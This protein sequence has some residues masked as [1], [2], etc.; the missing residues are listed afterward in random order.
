MFTINFK[1]NG[2]NYI[3][4]DKM[5]ESDKILRKFNNTTLTEIFKFKHK[6]RVEWQM[7]TYCLENKFYQ[8]QRTIWGFIQYL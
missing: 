8:Y 4:N 6:L 1:G 2:Q 3:T 5:E 7:L